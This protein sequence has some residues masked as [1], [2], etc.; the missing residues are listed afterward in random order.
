MGEVQN[1][2]EAL[3]WIESRPQDS[4]VRF[5]FYVPREKIDASLI[6]YRHAV[7]TF[8]ELHG[9][10]AQPKSVSGNACVKLC[11]F[12]EQASKSQSADIQQWAFSYDV[13]EKLFTFYIEWNEYDHHRSMRLVLDLIAHL[14]QKNPQLEQS[15]A[16]KKTLLDNLIS[17]IVG[18]ST[19]PVAKS[20]IKTV[21][22]FVSKNV[23]ALEDIRKCYQVYYE[24]TET[25]PLFVWGSFVSHLFNWMRLH[26]VSPAAGKFIVCL[27]RYLRQGNDGP[28]A[29]PSVDVWHWWLLDFLNKEPLLVERIKNY[30][31]IP[32]FKLDRPETL[33]FLQRM[34]ELRPVSETSK[35]AVDTAALLQL[36]A[37]ETGKKVGLVDEP[38]LSGDA[39]SLKDDSCIILHEKVLESVLAHPSH[40]VRSLAFSILITSPSTTKPYSSTAL[41]LLKKHIGAFFAD[42]DAKFRVDISAGA[43]DMFKRIRGAIVVLKRSIPR[44]RAKA[45]KA[46]LAGKLGD[47]AVNTS[48]PVLYR[49][50]LISLPEAQ[51]VECLE[52]HERFLKWYLSFLCDELIPTASYQRHIASLKALGSIFRLQS[53]NAKTWETPDEQEL[54]FDVFDDKWMRALFDLLMDPFDDVRNAT[55]IVL[56]SLFGNPRFRKFSLSKD[57]DITNACQDLVSFSAKANELARRTS[58]ADHA[59][60]VARISQLLYNFLGDQKQRLALLDQLISELDRK[61][62]LAETDLGRAVLDVPV[63]GDFAALSCTWQVVTQ[64]KASEEEIKLLE[65]LQGKLV[66]ACERIWNAVKNILC[67]DSPEGHLPQELEEMEGLDTKGLLS[68]SF[69]AVHESR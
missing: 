29:V 47:A 57:S 68:Y 63:H 33:L 41:D 37:L 44:A 28:S 52:Y 21:E 67:D 7:E 48:G 45:E 53:E 20:A 46:K 58:R 30:I 15:A 38:A 40:E 66:D 65:P 19:K 18:R 55:S 25:N 60:G 4:Q 14:L 16:T 64:L 6:R 11:G 32:L 5:V 22:H 24:G 51:L 36:A 43:R 61:I 1:P 31:F 10:A 26:F 69:R 12:V 17:I 39:E 2:V 50:N 42:A 13:V 62:T 54:F 59:D 23:F 35:E 27:Y 34:N 56:R 9:E 8:T 3:K 49:T